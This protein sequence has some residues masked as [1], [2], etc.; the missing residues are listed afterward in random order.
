MLKKISFIILLS[1]GM[2]MFSACSGGGSDSTS[3][4]VSSSVSGVVQKG[5]FLQGSIA[6]IYK[7]DANYDRNISQVVE[8]TISND[9]GAYSFTSIPWTGLSEIEVSGFFLNENTGDTNQSA[10]ITSIV[11]VTADGNVNTNVNVLTHMA[12]AKVKELLREGKS[13]DEA[14]E[15]VVGEVFGILGRTDLGI[16]DFG[17]L[18]LTDLL[19][20]NA[21][22]NTELLFLSAVLLQSDNYMQ[23]LEALLALY[24]EG[25]IEAVL[26]SSLYA[27]LMQAQQTLDITEVMSHVS[28]ASEIDLSTITLPA[29]IQITKSII[30]GTIEVQLYGTEFTEVQPSISFIVEGGVVTKGDVSISDDNKSATIAVSGDVGGCK[31]VNV[32]L[33]IDYMSLKDVDAMPLMSNKIN[34]HPQTLICAP[35]PDD[36]T[37]DIIVLPG[38]KIPVAY[39]GVVYGEDIIGGNLAE[40]EMQLITTSVGVIHDV[41]ASYSYD[42]DLYPYGS[43]IHCQWQDNEGSIIKESDDAMCDLEDIIFEVAGEYDYILTVTDNRDANDSNTLHI[44]VG[45]NNLPTVSID[46]SVAQSVMVGEVLELNA[47]VSDADAEDTLSLQWSYKKEEI[48]TSFGAGSTSQFSHI[49]ETVGAYTVTLNVV[50]TKGARAEASVEVTVTPAPINHEPTV[51]ISPAGNKSIGVGD[52][53]ILKAIA[54]DE[55]DDTLTYS[56]KMRNVLESEYIDVPLYGAYG[57]NQ[58]FSAVGTYIIVAEVEDSS[59]AKADANITVVVNEPQVEINLDD[60]SISLVVKGEN[61]FSTGLGRSENNVTLHESSEHGDIEIILIGNEVWDIIYTSV[62]CFVGED[63]FVYRRGSDY[64]RVNVTISAPTLEEVIDYSETLVKNS[65]IEMEYLVPN[66][67]VISITTPPAHG[68]A[69]LANPT[70]EIVFYSYEPNTDYVGE[71][72]FIYTTTETISSCQYSSTGR[73]D[74]NI[75]DVQIN[76]KLVIPFGDATNGIEPWSTD[77]SEAGTILIE[78]VVTGN[79]SSIPFE[80]SDLYRY[81]DAYYYTYYNGDASKFYRVTPEGTTVVKDAFT[82]SYFAD[83]NGILYFQGYTNPWTTS[84]GRV[85]YKSDG[86]TANIEIVKDMTPDTHLDQIITKLFRYDNK[87]FYSAVTNDGSNNNALWVSDGTEAGTSVLVDIYGWDAFDGIINEMAEA[88]GK[89]FFDGHENNDKDSLWISDGTAGGTHLLK[90]INPSAQADIRY[91]QGVGDTLFFAAKDENGNYHDLWKSDGTASG[92]TLL[93]VSDYSSIGSFESCNGKLYYSINKTLNISDGTVDGTLQIHE[94][95][96]TIGSDGYIEELICHDS[97]LFVKLYKNNVSGYQLYAMNTADSNTSL[98]VTAQSYNSL[99][100]SPYLLNEDL[101]YTTEDGINYE[102]WKYNIVDGNRLIKQ[103]SI[104]L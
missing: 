42:R 34:M 81:N 38:N 103:S 87:L 69:T 19:G 10:T 53:L 56:W 9:E 7:L 8:T 32:T 95:D 49:F 44:T 21:T 46:P 60:I 84:A 93:K 43:I 102:M 2:L 47:T 14:N 24:R 4:S 48:P 36:N 15:Q 41:V 29:R 28:D 31:D 57:I 76:E 22:A 16:N 89:L 6:K 99:N 18:D 25:G 77:G 20:S 91:M 82:A 72:F 45:E 94:F 23:D 67:P 64:G 61:H 54:L 83:L 30:S 63:S 80:Y 39:I 79:S 27:R 59:G 58:L 104:H 35:D 66:D 78:D 85:L 65:S 86:T 73:V 97:M 11:N 75:T 12:S 98:T 62:D 5:P 40:Q 74:F 33:S 3:S 101:I 55:D 50:D 52:S 68:V 26:G 13:L 88:G 17:D 96:D 70:H 90:V 37:T 100:I 71:D 1:L 51:R 92:T